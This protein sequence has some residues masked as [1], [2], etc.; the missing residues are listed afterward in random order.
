M[1]LSICLCLFEIPENL[2]E[3]GKTGVKNLVENGKKAKIISSVWS[4]DRM[5]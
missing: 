5:R 1:C 2:V 4:R 3:N